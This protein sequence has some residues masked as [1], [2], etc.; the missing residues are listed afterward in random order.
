MLSIIFIV[1]QLL[2][3]NTHFRNISH[4]KVNQTAATKHKKQKQES[5]NTR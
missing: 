5:K 3:P 1:Q 4:E 2:I